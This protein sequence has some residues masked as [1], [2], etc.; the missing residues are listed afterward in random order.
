MCSTSPRAV[1]LLPLD[2]ANSANRAPIGA[3]FC[4]IC[5]S[6]PRMPSFVSSAGYRSPLA[7]PRRPAVAAASGSRWEVP[8]PA[9]VA[10]TAAAPPIVHE[11]GAGPI[12]AAEQRD[13]EW[14]ATLDANDELIESLAARV[15]APPG[16]RL[17]RRLSAP[18]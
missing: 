14:L 13:T 18:A 4:L 8:P 15:H 2:R 17:E 16:A 10:A 7:S 5:T 9:A 1:G 3:L 11:P 12:E 6:R